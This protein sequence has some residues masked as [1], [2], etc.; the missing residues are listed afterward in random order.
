MRR[1][2]SVDAQQDIAALLDWSHN[3][4]GAAARA[5]YE[6]LIERGLDLIVERR[7][8][9][10]G[11]VLSGKVERRLYHLRNC[12]ADPVGDTVGTPRHVLVYRIVEPDLVILVR[13]LHDAMDM[14]AHFGD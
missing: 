6:R 4:F 7:E 2:I 9:A 14:P 3:H 1:Q 13:V 12:R 5:R 10:G 11:R 8:L